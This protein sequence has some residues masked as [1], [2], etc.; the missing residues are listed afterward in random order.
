MGPR[1]RETESTHDNLAEALGAARDSGGRVAVCRRR[2]SA[3][4]PCG[5]GP[6]PWCYWIEEAD[7][8]QPEELAAAIAALPPP[9]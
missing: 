6:C 7:D 4:G 2:E 5:G 8:R 1:Y 9:A 3:D